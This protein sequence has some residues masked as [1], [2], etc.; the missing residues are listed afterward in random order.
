MSK[1][2]TAILWHEFLKK[3]SIDELVKIFKESMK[4]ENENFKIYPII[5]MM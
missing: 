2:E 1:M 4:L 5:T 3:V